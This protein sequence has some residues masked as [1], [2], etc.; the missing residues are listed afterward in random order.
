MNVAVL[1]K[2]IPDPEVPAALDKDSF[3]L[4]RAAAS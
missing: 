2:Q 4:V 1:V 3:R